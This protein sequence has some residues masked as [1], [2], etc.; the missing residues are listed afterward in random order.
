MCQEIVQSRKQ[1]LFSALGLKLFKCTSYHW[2]YKG[3]TTQVTEEEELRKMSGKEYAVT[4]EAWKY[5]CD[6]CKRIKKMIW[7]LFN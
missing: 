3:P 4:Q 2:K 5:L 1:P 6:I 7:R